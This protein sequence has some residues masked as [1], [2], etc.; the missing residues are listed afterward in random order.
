MGV[1]MQQ[2]RALAERDDLAAELAANRELIR[3]TY[4]SQ[5]E[6][7]EF[8]LFLAVC[9]SRRLNPLSGHITAY[10]I[11]GQVSFSPNVAGARVIATRTGVYA[12][13]DDIFY[14]ATVTEHGFEHPTSATCT[15]YRLVQGQRCGFTATV[16][17][18]ERARGDLSKQGP[19]RS[20]PYWMLGTRAEKAALGRA[21]PEDFSGLDVEGEADDI[22][23]TEAEQVRATVAS[24]SR[25]FVV[26]R[27]SE[28]Q[29][30]AMN[31]AAAE[32]GVPGIY[33]VDREQT[34]STQTWREIHRA[35]SESYQRLGLGPVPVRVAPDGRIE[36]GNVFSALLDIQTLPLAEEG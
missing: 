19:W 26:D 20:Q 9:R 15:V 5:L 18:S 27:L 14:G 21:F 6:D 25:V 17:W 35:L 1:A 11:G 34:P 3:R 4:A 32:R 10:K 23:V 7:R 36:P 22:A 29:Q 12:G 16:R 31:N 2:M 13:M 24:P 30:E 28:P 33:P 8:E